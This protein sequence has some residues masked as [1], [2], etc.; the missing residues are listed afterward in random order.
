MMT[1][2]A[3]RFEVGGSHLLIR[4]LLP[5]TSDLP[6]F[7]E[8]FQVNEVCKQMG[9][10][11]GDKRIENIGDFYLNHV[12]SEADLS[13]PEKFRNDFCRGRSRFWVL[14]DEDVTMP[15]VAPSL[16]DSS[17]DQPSLKYESATGGRII[18]SIALEEKSRIEAELR[19]MV[20][21]VDYRRRGL[22]KVLNEHL[23]AYARQQGF[24]TVF[25]TTP[26]FNEPAIRMYKSVGYQVE[27]SGRGYEVPNCGEL[28]IT[29]LRI[30]L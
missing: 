8:L 6:A 19:R 10:A 11:T 18:G 23:L 15:T 27:W 21:S 25:L 20:V 3:F 22:G 4:T 28:L 13:S 12:F 14:I 2:E 9:R 26:D 30:H 29:Q 5:E 7:R 17:E 24:S 16:A 1:T